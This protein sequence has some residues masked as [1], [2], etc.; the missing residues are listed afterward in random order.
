MHKKKFSK[1]RKL[2]NRKINNFMID[3]IMMGKF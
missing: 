2:F 1:N 3:F